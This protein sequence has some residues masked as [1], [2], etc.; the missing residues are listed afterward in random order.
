MEKLVSWEAVSSRL[1]SAKAEA[2]EREIEEQRKREEEEEY[3]TANSEAV[4][5]YLENDDSE[6]DWFLFK[7]IGFWF[8]FDMILEACSSKH[9]K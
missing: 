5:M 1:K 3:G 7:V 4:E 2:T 9:I 6:A 8:N